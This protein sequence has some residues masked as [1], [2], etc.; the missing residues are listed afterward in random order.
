MSLSGKSERKF[1]NIA[2]IQQLTLLISLTNWV[3][4]R[5]VPYIPQVYIKQTKA[6]QLSN[7]GWGVKEHQVDEVHSLKYEQ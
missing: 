1:A 2:I 5:Q 4:T 7:Q 6:M 3:V